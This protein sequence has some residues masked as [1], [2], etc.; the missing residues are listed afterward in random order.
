MKQAGRQN[1]SSLWAWLVG[2]PSIAPIHPPHW[3]CAQSH[4]QH[5]CSCVS[6]QPAVCHRSSYAQALP[7]KH[8]FSCRVKFI[9]QLLYYSLNSIIYKEIYFENK[10][11]TTMPFFKK[12]KLHH[13][14]TSH[15]F[16]R[17]CPLE[18]STLFLSGPEIVRG[19]SKV[20]QGWQ[21]HRTH[22]HMVDYT[23]GNS[24]TMASFKVI[25][26]AMTSG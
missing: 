21:A 11:K 20:Q 26:Q 23:G 24:M 2:Y 6:L 7:A 13:N 9:L 3:P 12:G 16:D 15:Q 10:D 5:V 22:S 14:S 4:Y 17:S 1:P 25:C 19:W 8:S 18:L